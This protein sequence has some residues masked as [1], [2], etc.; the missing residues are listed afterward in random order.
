M[1]HADAHH[2][3]L[4]LH[5]L[6]SLDYWKHTRCLRNKLLEYNIVA[7]AGGLLVVRTRILSLRESMDDLCIHCKELK[8]LWPVW[9]FSIRWR[10]RVA[11]SH[12]FKVQFGTIRTKLCM[13]GWW[14]TKWQT[15][16]RW[17]FTRIVLIVRHINCVSRICSNPHKWQE[18]N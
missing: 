10:T 11:F 5:A 8:Q 17:L 18:W 6:R 13:W 9:R 7:S 14:W 2:L 12:R 4:E 15:I 3:R 16:T 1:W